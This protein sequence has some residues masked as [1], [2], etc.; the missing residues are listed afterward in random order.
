VVVDAGSHYVLIA[1]DAS[2]QERYMLEGRID[3][4]AVDARLH[5]DS[6]R[7]IR[8][9]CK[10]KSTITQFAHDPHSARRLE[11]KTFTITDD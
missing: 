5:H 10:R 11:E 7:R 2:Y 4:V 1:G 8:E 6:T 9:L 3:G